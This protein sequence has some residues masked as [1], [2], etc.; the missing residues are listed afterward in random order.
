[1]CPKC[2]GLK[3]EDGSSMC[4]QISLKLVAICTCETSAFACK[5][6]QKTNNL[7]CNRPF[8]GRTYATCWEPLLY[9]YVLTPCCWTSLI[10]V[11]PFPVMLHTSSALST[12]RD[13][14]GV[15]GLCSVMVVMGSYLRSY[16]PSSGRAGGSLGNSH[17]HHFQ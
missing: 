15:A 11:L 12:S 7:Y 2:S 10:T 1:V 14:S 8:Y 4:P 5:T 13:K 9:I 3:P 16:G 6:T 17:V